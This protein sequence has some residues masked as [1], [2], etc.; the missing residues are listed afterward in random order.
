VAV[1]R[2]YLSPEADAHTG[3]LRV[4]ELRSAIRAAD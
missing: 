3:V 2:F 4:S 1:K